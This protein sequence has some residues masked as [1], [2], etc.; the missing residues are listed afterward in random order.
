MSYNTAIEFNDIPQNQIEISN[1]NYYYIL[2]STP[3]PDS[4][5]P[6]PDSKETSNSFRKSFELV[7]FPKNISSNNNNTSVN[8]EAK[9]NIKK[10]QNIKKNN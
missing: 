10:N 5:W 1:L 3:K 6:L 9:E 8:N 4:L 7:F 2:E